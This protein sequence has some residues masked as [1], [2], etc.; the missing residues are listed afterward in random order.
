MKRKS[1]TVQDN[2][3]TSL[4]S[5]DRSKDNKIKEEIVTKP[6]TY[7]NKKFNNQLNAINLYSNKNNKNEIAEFLNEFEGYNML[8]NFEERK[9]GVP[10]PID[11]NEINLFFS[12]IKENQKF[13]KFE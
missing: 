13:F 11:I 8:D 3:N 4:L 7:Q 10:S 2:D 9:Y 12:N 1:V 5:K 6:R